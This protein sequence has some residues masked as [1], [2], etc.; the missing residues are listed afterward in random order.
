MNHS[1]ALIGLIAIISTLVGLMPPS[2]LTARAA[3]TP[4]I[5]ESDLDRGNADS[6]HRVA[7]VF[8]LLSTYT[9]IDEGTHNICCALEEDR[10][11][12]GH[13]LLSHVYPST[14]DISLSGSMF[15]PN[16]E[17]IMYLKPDAVFVSRAFAEPLEKIGTP[18]LN[19]IVFDP[20]QRERDSAKI[21]DLVGRVAKKSPR[22]NT[23]MSKLLESLKDLESG[24]VEETTFP[25][26]ALPVVATGAGT[27]SVGRK[28]FFLNNLMQLVGGINPARN[29]SFLGNIGIEQLIKMD[30]EVIILIPSWSVPSNPQA[31]YDDPLWQPIR[32]AQHRR[33][34]LMPAV[35]SFNQ[36][37]DEQLTLSWMREI[38]HPTSTSRTTRQLYR[39]V[40]QNIY[41]YDLSDEEI[42]QAL[43]LKENIVSAGYERFTRP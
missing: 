23:L 7:M 43:F 9:T 18:G 2:V 13:S 11:L 35:S 39:D 41:R 26:R 4:G 19:E 14:R 21:W 40:Y 36:P 16:L 29:Q 33:V 5:H 15:H 24:K 32:A 8:P 12:A 38:F 6:P 22:A 31:L 1:S 30:P 3:L 34:Y 37:V 17:T 27:W 10:F 42:D 28:N 20:S 25:V